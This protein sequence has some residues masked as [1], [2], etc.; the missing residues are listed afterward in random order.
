[1]RILYLWLPHSES[2]MLASMPPKK[3]NPPKPLKN[4]ELLFIR[5]DPETMTALA[6][7][8]DSFEVKPERPAVGLAA[9]RNFLSERGYLPKAK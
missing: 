2:C 5:M 8:I 1:M 6:A 9:L 7:Y 4:P 3:K